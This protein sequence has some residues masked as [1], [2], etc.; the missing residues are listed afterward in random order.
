MPR[1]PEGDGEK[2]PTLQAQ[3]RRKNVSIVSATNIFAA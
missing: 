2:A 1:K 3:R